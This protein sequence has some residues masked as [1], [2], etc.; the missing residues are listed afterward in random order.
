MYKHANS[1]GIEYYLNHKEVSFGGKNR[2]IY[3]FSKDE[4]DTG[5][6][7]PEGYSVSENSK[8]H[9][10]CLKKIKKEE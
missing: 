5:C 4:R 10:I 7:L 3:F 9:F 8:N 6:D 1:K 2:V